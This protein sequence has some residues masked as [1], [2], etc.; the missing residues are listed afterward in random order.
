MNPCTHKPT[1]EI[2]I[3]IMGQKMI[4]PTCVCTQKVG[5]EA[6]LGSEADRTS[7]TSE[8]ADD[9]DSVN[10]ADTNSTQ[11]GE[12]VNPKGVRFLQQQQQQQSREGQ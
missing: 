2:Y 7:Y 11:E 12:F 9:N 4:S 8:V 6:E 3:H 10:S 1:Q 5:S